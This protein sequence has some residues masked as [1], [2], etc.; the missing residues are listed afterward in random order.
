MPLTISSSALQLAAQ[1]VVLPEVRIIG[2]AIALD[3]QHF[4]AVRRKNVTQRGENRREHVPSIQFTAENAENAE[5]ELG[6]SI[7]LWSDAFAAI[8]PSALSAFSA[9]NSFG[10]RYPS[11]Q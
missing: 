6:V 2:P 10:Q 3:Q 4:F 7:T 11:S 9:V 1:A 5:T 8:P